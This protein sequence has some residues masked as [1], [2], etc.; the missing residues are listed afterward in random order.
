LSSVLVHLTFSKKISFLKSSSS[1]FSASFSKFSEL[2]LI[3]NKLVSAF[4]KQCVT[5]MLYPLIFKATKTELVSL[6][7]SQT[8]SVSRN[9]LKLLSL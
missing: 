5:K 4:Q 8:I 3:N 7:S 1:V 9:V 2:M 6:G